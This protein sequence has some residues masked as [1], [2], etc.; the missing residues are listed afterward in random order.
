MDSQLQELAQVR[1]NES[2]IHEMD[3]ISEDSDVSYGGKFM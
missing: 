3:Q 1:N 2:F